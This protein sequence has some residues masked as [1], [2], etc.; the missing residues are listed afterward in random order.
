[1]KELKLFYAFLLH[2]RLVVIT[3]NSKGG[4]AL[5]SKNEGDVKQSVL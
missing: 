4:Q 3:F 5:Q 2:A 1:M